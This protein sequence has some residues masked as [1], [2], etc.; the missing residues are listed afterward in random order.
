MYKNSKGGETSRPRTKEDLDNCCSFSDSHS[1]GDSG[2]Y[3]RM[4]GEMI[5][6]TWLGRQTGGMGK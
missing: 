5:G 2:M 4:I 3:E 1:L 6:K